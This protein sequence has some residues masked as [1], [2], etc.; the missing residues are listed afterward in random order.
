MWAIHRGKKYESNWI[1]SPS[2]FLGNRSKN[3]WSYHLE[4]IYAWRY[5]IYPMFGLPNWSAVSCFLVLWKD[6]LETPWWS[7]KVDE[8]HL[9]KLENQPTSSQP[10]VALNTNM[11][12]SEGCELLNARAWLELRNK[13]VTLPE[14]NSKSPW[15][16]MAGW[17]PLDSQDLMNKR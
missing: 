15:K 11:T 1:I 13:R 9:Q 7:T 8:N 10:G 2:F 3:D 5:W 16:W 12:S 4:H 14:T 6:Y 17:L